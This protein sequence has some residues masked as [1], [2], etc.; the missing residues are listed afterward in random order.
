MLR[1]IPP[2]TAKDFWTRKGC[3]QAESH[4]SGRADADAELIPRGAGS[5]P[6]GD[7]NPMLQIPEADGSTENS[8]YRDIF[9]RLAS[10]HKSSDQFV[11]LTEHE[12]EAQWCRHFG[13][14]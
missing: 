13:T 9:R 6:F 7:T 12:T 3:G 4:L 8:V 14:V 11:S 5:P 2:R 10:K 1:V